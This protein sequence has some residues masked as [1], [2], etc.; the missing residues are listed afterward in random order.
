M[1]VIVAT[2]TK[3][4]DI[5][6]P[7]FDGKVLRFP[8]ALIDRGDIGT[9]RQ[10]SKTRS[11]RIRVEI[12]DSRLKTWGLGETDL[13]KV[14]FEIAKEQLTAA[15]SSSAWKGGDL[16]VTVNTNTHKGPC[17]FDP[18]LIQEPAGA[19]VEIEVM[20]LIGFL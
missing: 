5:T 17:P 9:P 4:E 14:L 16:E 20:R 1:S 11:V 8:L 6:N 18:A 7:G 10:P 2:F 3:P 13:R 15:L 19:V 12:S